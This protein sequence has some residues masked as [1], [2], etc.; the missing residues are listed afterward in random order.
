MHTTIL[1]GTNIGDNVIIGANSL[2]NKDI[3]SNCVAAGNPIK[4]IMPLDTYYM[5]RKEIKIEKHLIENMEE[6]EE[7]FS[8]TKDIVNFQKIIEME[9]IKTITYLEQE[10]GR[11]KL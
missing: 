5:K 7:K 4:I 8:C 3:P 11:Q 6:I 10:I 2:V 1:K 9:R